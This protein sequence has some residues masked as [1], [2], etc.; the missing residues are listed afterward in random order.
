MKIGKYQPEHTNRK[1]THQENKNRR[2][3]HRGI[4]VNKIQFG[5]IQI[6][7]YTSEK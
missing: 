2:N 1:K 5:R 3:T 7:K 6:G 4:H